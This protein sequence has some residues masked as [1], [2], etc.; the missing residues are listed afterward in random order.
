MVQHIIM[1]ASVLHN[2]HSNSKNNNS[3]IPHV[4]KFIMRNSH[5]E[6]LFQFIAQFVLER[7]MVGGWEWAAS[8][9][10]RE[11]F[12]SMNWN[13]LLCRTYQHL[14]RLLKWFM[15]LTNTKGSGSGSGPHTVH[16]TNTNIWFCIIEIEHRIYEFQY[17]V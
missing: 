14:T 15:M 10:F 5:S 13:Q 9:N 8:N 1:Y 17:K 6:K 7:R 11:K 2:C 12:Y 4:N 3:I 16:C